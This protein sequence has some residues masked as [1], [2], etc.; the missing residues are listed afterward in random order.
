MEASTLTEVTKSIIILNIT[1]GVIYFIQRFE[2]THRCSSF[3]NIFPLTKIA[4]N[5]DSWRF[6]SQY[7]LL[8]ELPKLR[9]AAEK[10]KIKLIFANCAT[11]SECHPKRERAVFRSAPKT[12]FLIA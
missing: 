12:F 2:F 5:T 4:T 7:E 9:V 8:K 10:K 1:R 11:S 3:Q 6:S